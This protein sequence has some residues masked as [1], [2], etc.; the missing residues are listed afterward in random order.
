MS[1]EEIFTQADG[2]SLI[3]F[4]RENIENFLKTGTKTPIPEKF[5]ELFLDKYGA[6]VTL[7]R[8]KVSGNPL[9][10]CIGFIEP[11]YPLYEVVHKVSISSAIEDPRF[12]PVTLGEM[13]NHKYRFCFW[14]IKGI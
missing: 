4:A 6:F 13:D 2:K 9:R 7:N 12:S 11:I 10:G 1:E 3:Q 5:K 8:Y 14:F